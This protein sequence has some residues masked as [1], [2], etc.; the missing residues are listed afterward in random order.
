[1]HR[2]LYVFEVIT[3]YPPFWHGALEHG[4]LVVRLFA[5]G[6]SSPPGVALAKYMY[7]I[8]EINRNC[9]PLLSK[10]IAAW[11]SIWIPLIGIV[12]I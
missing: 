2:Q 9:L 6:Y 11:I 4:V 7:C 8:G 12:T 1:M 10:A 5:D 3:Q